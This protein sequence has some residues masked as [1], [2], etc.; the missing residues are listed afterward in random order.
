MRD[1]CE[2]RKKNCAHAQVRE[3][4]NL[5][6]NNCDNDYHLGKVGKVK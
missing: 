6:Q 4:L 1:G 2:L 3:C 5:W